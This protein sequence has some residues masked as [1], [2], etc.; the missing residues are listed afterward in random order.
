MQNITVVITLYCILYRLSIMVSGLGD[1]QNADPQSMDYPNGLPRRTTP[2]V[3]VIKKKTKLSLFQMQV[4]LT[5]GSGPH[6]D[7]LVAYKILYNLFN[8][9]IWPPEIKR[10]C[11][12]T[13][14]E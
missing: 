5:P 9:Y 6:D 4:N 10:K 2:A 8:S 1:G 13:Y 12:M 7:G 14:L 11:A 3:L